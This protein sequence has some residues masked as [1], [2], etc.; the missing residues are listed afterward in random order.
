M[1]RREFVATALAL[2]AST[3]IP[4]S[5]ISAAEP[6]QFNRGMIMKRAREL[7]A[8][9]FK[10]PQP[11]APESLRNLSYSQYQSIRF[12]PEERLWSDLNLN[13]TIDLFH[14]GFIYTDPVEIYL[15]DD[16]MARKIEFSRDM[17][18]YGGGVA[19]PPPDL[20]LEF[21][22]FRARAP[23]NQ[24]GVMDEFLVF[25]GASY[26]RAIARGQNY[27]LSARALAINTGEP[28]GEEFPF[29][30]AFWLERPDSGL[31]VVH[32]LLD[33]PSTTG[34]YRF[35]V[36]PGEETVMDVEAALFTRSEI[37]R[38][39]LAPLT[40]MFLFNA[41]TQD[42]YDD[43]RPAVHDSDGLAIW[44]GRDEHLWRPLINPTELQISAFVDTGLRGFGL[45][46]RER[47][48]VEYEDLEALYHQRPSLWVEPIGDWQRGSVVLVEIPTDQE[49]HDNIVC[50]WAPREP[51]PAASEFTYTY[52]LYW[53]WQA[54]KMPEGP[55]V[56]RTLTGSSADEQRRHFVVDY[57]MP[58]G[59]FVPV[60]EI[61]A[62]INTWPA[63]LVR[64]QTVRGNPE[65]NGMR[66]SFE[67]ITEGAELIESRIDLTRNGT[68]SYGES[69]VYRWT[70]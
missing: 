30:R 61:E 6:E 19:P 25:L 63:G 22:G 53:A 37:K 66:V 56:V 16:S 60:E 9:S 64:N 32:A 49:I 10:R 1:D 58:D 23:I 46:Q 62:S 42:T 51:I 68:G 57:A 18:V 29:F 13:Y 34:A 33:S 69:W 7:A 44:N 41:M 36:R 48:F 67:L 40:S 55:I 11:R 65:L 4:S 15:V 43:F 3:Q 45:M 38:V 5:S 31:L 2:T 70:P 47:R 35:S 14:T 54:P 21:A 12:K 24:G 20:P 52:R 27:G 17:F 26:F 50:F 39:G 59:S 28:E 8:Q